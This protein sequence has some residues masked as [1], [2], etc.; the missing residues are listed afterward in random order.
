MLEA[1]DNTPPSS[2]S[3][4]P[5]PMRNAS[6]SD[7]RVLLVE[8]SP[9][10]A[11]VASAILSSAGYR[12]DVVVD[13]IAALAAARSR[14]Y[15][16][17]FMDCQLPGIDGYETTRRLRALERDGQLPSTSSSRAAIP[18]IA[19]TAA[20][21]KEDVD[22]C[23]AAGMNDHLPKPVD[24]QRLLAMMARHLAFPLPV[25]APPDKPEASTGPAIANLSRALERMRGDRQLLRRVS[26]QFAESAPAARMELR[27]AVERKDTAAASYAA[28]RLKG[29]AASFDGDACAAALVAL[30]EALRSE[31]WSAAAGALVVV[32]TELDALLRTI[33]AAD[34]P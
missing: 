28:H 1:L 11:E 19:L 25:P 32:E 14:P 29:Q 13:G 8:D 20:V 2:K 16:L 7:V 3:L 12:F 9:V 26:S 33:F 34:E 5:T 10:N 31:R 24:A 22:R 15:D 27:S 23:R 6:S 17:V 4:P 21:M 30:E 18:I